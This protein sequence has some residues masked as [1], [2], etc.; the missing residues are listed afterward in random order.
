MTDTTRLSTNWLKWTTIAHLGD[1]SVSRDCDDCLIAFKAT[2]YAF[3]LRH[4]GPWWVIDTVDDRGQRHIDV[5]KLSTF[6]LAEKY[7]IWRWASIARGIIGVERLG[8]RLYK[9]GYSGDVV[10]TPLAPGIAELHSAVG[11]AILMEPD[12]TIFSHVI[13]RSIDEIERMMTD[14]IA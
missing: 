8:P 6:E 14:G 11:D 3:H 5:A 13:L 7:L 12:S 9:L 1:V 4:T 10:V 2:D